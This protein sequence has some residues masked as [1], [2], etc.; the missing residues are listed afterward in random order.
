MSLGCI[1]SELNKSF[2]DKMMNTVRIQNDLLRRAGCGV[3]FVQWLRF[4]R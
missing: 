3:M 4:P 1:T 2:L